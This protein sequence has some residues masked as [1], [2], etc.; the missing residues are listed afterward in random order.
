M[1]NKVLWI[2]LLAVTVSFVIFYPILISMYVYLP[3]FIGFAGYMI[4]WGIDGHGVRYIWFPMIYLLNLEA[5]LSLPIFLSLMAVLLFYLTLYEKVR[6]FKRCSVC[7]GLLSVIAINI[8]YFVL[9]LGYDFM[10]DTTSIFVDSLLLYSLIFD[11]IFVV[12]I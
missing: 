9:L 2:L 10:F 4:I 11:L 7:V 12:L 1:L 5:N 8:Y 3:L 6:Y